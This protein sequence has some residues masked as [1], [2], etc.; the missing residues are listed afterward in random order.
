VTAWQKGPNPGRV[1]HPFWASEFL[2]CVG[3]ELD[4]K[5]YEAVYRA[6]QKYGINHLDFGVTVQSAKQDGFITVEERDGREFICFTDA[7]RE[8]QAWLLEYVAHQR[9]RKEWKE[10]RPH[11]WSRMPRNFSASSLG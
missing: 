5:S 8:R 1:V 7:G 2:L 4:G 11:F 9:A 3:E 6:Y 10:V